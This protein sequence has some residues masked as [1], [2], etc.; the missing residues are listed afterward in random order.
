MGAGVVDDVLLVQVVNKRDKGVP[1]YFV[2]SAAG[3]GANEVAPPCEHFERESGDQSNL[4]KALAVG[5]TPSEKEG[6][7]RT[8]LL[9]VRVAAFAMVRVPHWS[10][11]LDGQIDV[12]KAREVASGERALTLGID[13]AL[14][15]KDERDVA[16]NAKA[17]QSLTNSGSEIQWDLLRDEYGEIR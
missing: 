3:V 17:A 1:G 14:T 10:R 5:K 12:K 6:V 15:R 16:G 13:M 7:F 4:A 9:S 2:A 8:A 11:I